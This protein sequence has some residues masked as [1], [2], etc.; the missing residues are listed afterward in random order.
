MILTIPDLAFVI[1][2]AFLVIIFIWPSFDTVAKLRTITISEF[3]LIGFYLQSVIDKFSKIK[4][5]FKKNICG[6]S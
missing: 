4:V 5:C 1:V 6:Q 2:D 3:P